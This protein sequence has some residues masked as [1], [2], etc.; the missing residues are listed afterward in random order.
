MDSKEARSPIDVLLECSVKFKPDPTTFQVGVSC[1][2]TRLDRPSQ[3]S[4]RVRSQAQ[5]EASPCCHTHTCECF[6]D[7]LCS[8][9]L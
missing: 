5:Q 1:V 3:P 6:D 2:S 7:V 4:S 8:M 9:A